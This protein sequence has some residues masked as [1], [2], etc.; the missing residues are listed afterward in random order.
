MKD[1]PLPI[2]LKDT[3]K[4]IAADYLLCLLSFLLLFFVGRCNISS[5][6]RNRLNKSFDIS[7]LSDYIA[8][9]V[10]LHKLTILLSLTEIAFIPNTVSI[11]KHTITVF[12]P[13]LESA[14]EFHT[15]GLTHD[16]LSIH[17][18]ILPLSIIHIIVGP[19]VF[20][21]PMLVIVLPL[22]FVH[23]STMPSERSYTTLL[24]IHKVSHIAVSIGECEYSLSCSLPV[25]ILPIVTTAIVKRIYTMAMLLVSLEGTTVRITGSISVNALAVHHIIL[26][27]ALIAVSIV[28][29]KNTMPVL[30]VILP[31][32]RVRR[33]VYIGVCTFA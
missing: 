1:N 4:C 21:T 17:T 5:I 6:F 25:L 9:T 11:F 30:L 23:G 10:F 15:I 12:E 13:I 18:A 8:I 32:S 14:F 22:S 7:N 24:T 33:A 26:P 19:S 2:G 20:A 28:P 31:V 16:A 3:S 27:V 29:I